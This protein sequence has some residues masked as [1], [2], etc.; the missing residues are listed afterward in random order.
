IAR[1][2]LEGIAFRCAEVIEALRADSPNDAIDVLRV[3]GGASQNDFLMQC[4]ADITGLVIERPVVVDAATLGAAYLAGL[5]TGFWRD[6][7]LEEARRARAWSDVTSD[8]AER[9]V[10]ARL[11]AADELRLVIFDCDGVLFESWKANVA[12]YDAVLAALGLPPLDDDARR[13]CHTLSSPQLYAHLF[14]DDPQMQQRMAETAR[15][16]D[17]GPVYARM[18]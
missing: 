2:V 9:E 5:A 18:A 15:R 7:A 17:Y 6:G 16:T 13:L 1:A 14:R 10:R 11:P 3:D 12:F 4:Q 8:R